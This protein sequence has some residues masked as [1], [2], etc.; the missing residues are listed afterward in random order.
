MTLQPRDF[1]A[2]ARQA[3]RICD[4]RKARDIR[5]LDV[6]RSSG[7]ADYFVLATA[8][9]STHLQAVQ[10]HITQNLKDAHGLVPLHRDGAG[11]AQWT[12]LDYGG[13][14]IH[15]M[16]PQAREFYQLERLWEDARPV[17]WAEDGE[18]PVKRPPRARPAK[19]G[20]KAAPKK[21]A[22]SRRAGKKARRG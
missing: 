1:L 3:A 17:E 4:D 21:R 19:A 9:S 10:H 11:S 20:R 14:V 16:H 12:V 7:L 5:L 18:P 22:P 15:L 2:L 8:E 13:L 6:R